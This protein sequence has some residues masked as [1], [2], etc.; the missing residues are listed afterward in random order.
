MFCFV[1]YRQ[2]PL[3][4]FIFQKEKKKTKYAKSE[5]RLIDTLDT[6]CEKLLDYRVHKVGQILQN[7][8]TVVVLISGTDKTE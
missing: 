3:L 8:P 1:L 2:P 4:C 5:L 7:N 6:V